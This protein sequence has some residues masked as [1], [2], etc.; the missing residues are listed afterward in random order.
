MQELNPDSSL[1]VYGLM[2]LPQQGIQLQARIVNG[3][4]KVHLIL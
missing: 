4:I 3:R 2:I 1:N